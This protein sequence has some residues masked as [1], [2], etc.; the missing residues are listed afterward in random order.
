MN[1]IVTKIKLKMSK[2]DDFIWVFLTLGNE[3]FI[4]ERGMSVSQNLSK[5]KICI[6]HVSKAHN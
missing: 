4:Y 1:V 2:S 6:C 3:V 5:P